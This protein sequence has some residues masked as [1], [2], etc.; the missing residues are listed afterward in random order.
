MS[1]G[2][3]FA[4]NVLSDLI[5]SLFSCIAVEVMVLSDLEMYNSSVPVRQND[6]GGQQ[7]SCRDQTG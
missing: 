6:D 2:G 4:A 7:D 3:I 1:F 5:T